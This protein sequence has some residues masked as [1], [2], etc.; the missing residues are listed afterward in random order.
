MKKYLEPIKFLLLLLLVAFLYGFASNRNSTIKTSDMNI[1]FNNGKNL[2]IS[3]EKVNKLLIQNLAGLENQSKENINLNNVEQFLEN[4]QM[5]EEAE[6]FQ[7]ING[8]LGAVITQRT[9]VLRVANGLESHYYDEDGEKMPLSDN[10]SARIPL[11]TSIIEKDNCEDIILLANRI[12][13]DE[14]LKKHIIG[15]QQIKG[16][17]TNQFEL[18]M[19][20]GSQI[21]IFG[22]LKRMDKKIQNLKTFYQKTILDG[23]LKN[24]KTINLKFN[25]QVVCTKY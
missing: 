22:D 12:K 19:R 21:V 13:N 15:I 11:T 9:P 23:S 20:T 24:Y 8:V 18:K 25:D 1:I 14:F 4:N 2:F 7:T 5:I 6:I 3:Y 10:F 16:K 17:S